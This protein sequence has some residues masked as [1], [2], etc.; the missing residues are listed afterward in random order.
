M[1]DYETPR[2]GGSGK[3]AAQAYWNALRIFQGAWHELSGEEIPRLGNR[4][5]EAYENAIGFVMESLRHDEKRRKKLRQVLEIEGDEEIA[6]ALLRRVDLDDLTPNLIKQAIREECYRRGKGRFALR[7]I[8]RA[9]LDAIVDGKKGPRPRVGPNRHWPRLLQYLREL[10]AESDWR[11]QG[12]GL[13]LANVRG[14]VAEAPNGPG[15]LRVNIDPDF[16]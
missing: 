6:E 2:G 16:L 9:V 10:E 5:K 12:R 3:F 4:A 7:P 1:P 15:L 11:P 8:L 13:W 14:R